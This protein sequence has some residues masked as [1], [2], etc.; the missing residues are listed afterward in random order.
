MDFELHEK[1]RVGAPLK[2][3]GRIEAQMT[4]FVCSNLPEG[5]SKWTVRLLA[6]KLAEMAVWIRF[7]T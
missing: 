6:D 7:L 1:A 4:L 2:M 5:R 3:D